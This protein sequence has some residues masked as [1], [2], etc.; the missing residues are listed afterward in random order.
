MP[1]DQWQAAAIRWLQEAD[2]HFRRANRW[3]AA[4]YVV[5]AVAVMLGAVVAGMVMG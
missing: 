5:G 2:E 3:R 4:A 1:A